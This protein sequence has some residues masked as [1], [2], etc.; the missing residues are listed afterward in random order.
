MTK[1]TSPL[2]FSLPFSWIAIVTFAG[3]I[4]AAAGQEISIP[5]DLLEA[6]EENAARQTEP[7]PEIEIEIPDE[8]FE[9]EADT[10]LIVDHSGTPKPAVEFDVDYFGYFH[11]VPGD[12][13]FTRGDLKIEFADFL[14]DSFHYNLTPR[15][16]LDSSDD[17]VNEFAFRENSARRP[18]ATF[19][20][21]YVSWA[22]ERY[23]VSLGKKIFNWGVADTYN[24]LDDLNPRDFLDV[25]TNDRIG[26]P[27]LSVFRFGE[28]FDVQ[29]VWEPLFSPSRIPL[30]GIENRW[31]PSFRGIPP[32]FDFSGRELPSD[33]FENGQGAVRLSSSSLIDGWDLALSWFRGR[34][35]AGV[36][37][38]VQVDNAILTS[39]E[40]PRYQELGGSF[41]TVV[42]DWQIHG[43]G[44]W[45]VT[46]DER[47]DDDYLE[48][49][50]GVNRTFAGSPI[51]LVNEWILVFEYAGQETTRSIPEGGPFFGSRQFARPF[52]DALAATV[53][54]KVSDETQFEFG[55]AYDFADSGSV[56]R[57][58]FSH[59]LSAN[60]ELEIGSDFFSGPEDSFFG[61]WG[62]NDRFFV[63]IALQY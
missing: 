9:P 19:Q 6:A 8:L 62:A 18:L 13:H 51:P 43:E 53:T 58:S 25:P 48:Y 3:F 29:A 45:H 60:L 22:S 27:A 42:G 46:D 63:S 7:E 56:V 37:R 17:T 5:D 50:F 57:A 36:F 39:L 54:L 41:S 1:S 2:S 26:V 59:E 24:P 61:K 10:A 11:S 55:G 49:V 32:G 30:P 14:G 28:V 34:Q 40:Y 38:G 16:R 12:R 44:S 21:A 23:E 47:K 20:E 31:L 4:S 33:Q 35:S 15:F 52:Q